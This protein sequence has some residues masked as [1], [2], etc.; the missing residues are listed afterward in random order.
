MEADRRSC[1]VRA[2]KGKC[3]SK[4][5]KWGEGSSDSTTISYSRLLPILKS[6]YL[7]L[8]VSMQFGEEMPEM[9]VSSWKCPLIRTGVK[10]CV[11]NIYFSCLGGKKLS[12][13]KNQEV[14][15]P[16]FPPPHRSFILWRNKYSTGTWQSEVRNISYSLQLQASAALISHVFCGD[17]IIKFFPYII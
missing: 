7:S 15:W 12:S 14:S 9:L 10:L 17:W 6:T 2:H 1:F 11:F 8:L 4:G 5:M 3:Q 13:D 16:F